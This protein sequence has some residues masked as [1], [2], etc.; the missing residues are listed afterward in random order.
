MNFVLESYR[1]VL[2]IFL[3]CESSKVSSEAFFKVPDDPPEISWEIPS[4]ILA[5]IPPVIFMQFLEE[6]LKK[7]ILHEYLKIPAGI[8]VGIPEYF[9]DGTTEFRKEFLK[10]FI[11]TPLEEFPKE[12]IF[13]GVSK[14][15]FEKS[16]AEIL[17]EISKTLKK[18]LDIFL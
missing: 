18:F 11:E 16:L 4:E 10:D 2:K 15:P 8:S 14:K 1:K 5:R 6:L 17:E 12:W 9:S 13:S 3:F 7:K